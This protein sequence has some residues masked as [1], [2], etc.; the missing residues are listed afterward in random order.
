[1]PNPDPPRYSFIVC[2]RNRAHILGDCLDSLLVQQKG[3]D[4]EVVVIDDGSTD[5]TP[6]VVAERALARPVVKTRCVS[7][8]HG[9]LNRARNNGIESSRGEIL[10]FLDDDE[11]APKDFLAKVER[12]LTDD[13]DGVGGPTRD[14]GGTT[15]PTC[16]GCALGD[17]DV[18]GQGR[19]VTDR[20][21]GG[22]MA[23]RRRAFE[24]VGPFDPDLSG[25]GDDGEWFRR[26]AARRLRFVQDP[27]LWV[28][29]RRD[30]FT[31]RQLVSHAFTQGRSTP[32]FIKKTGVD[33][34][35][36]ALRVV[37]FLG[38]AL[39]RR[40]SRGVVLAMRELGCLAEMARL[41]LGGSP[42]TG[43]S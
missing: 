13:L 14:F 41:R 19:R 43:G 10:I 23:V 37:R 18:R 39:R 6:E 21:L 5:P 34:K 17:V 36:S 7:Q 24:V 38:H 28:W 40:C 9:G 2:T 25:R 16:P 4:Y 20:L 12:S 30:H 11:M 42:M 26:E 31:F 8:A 27:E 1:M 29:H 15:L 3:G 22:N 35:P 32:L 33:Y